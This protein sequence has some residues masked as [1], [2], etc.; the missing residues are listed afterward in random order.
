MV[1][2]G[3]DRGCRDRGCRSSV[4]HVHPGPPVAA[5]HGRQDRAPKK[6][7]P[8]WTSRDGK[9]P[10]APVSSASSSVTR[11]NSWGAR[12]VTW[13]L[14]RMVTHEQ[15]GRSTL[16]FNDTFFFHFVPQCPKSSARGSQC[17]GSDPEPWPAVHH[18]MP[19]R[20]PGHKEPGVKRL[21]WGKC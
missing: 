20:I 17:L 10:P 16:P 14:L 9:Q 18:S 4:S 13:V 7:A 1:R 12:W 6:R 3:R 11:A 15:I 19:D 5:G 2:G 8:F 21:P